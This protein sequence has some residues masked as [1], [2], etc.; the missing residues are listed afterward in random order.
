MSYVIIKDENDEIKNA[1]CSLKNAF[2]SDLAF[3]IEEEL[4]RG[5]YIREDERDTIYEYFDEMICDALKDYILIK[6]K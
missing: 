3:K 2:C 4:C 1:F 6:K 5:H